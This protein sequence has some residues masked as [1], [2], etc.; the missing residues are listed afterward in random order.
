MSEEQKDFPSGLEWKKES[1][2]TIAVITSSHISNPEPEP[3]T[4][5][6]VTLL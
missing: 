1:K 2:K 6:A 3:E 4:I 5:I